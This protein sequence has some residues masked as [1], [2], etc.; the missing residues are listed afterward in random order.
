MKSEE[1]NLFTEAAF[2]T[3]PKMV[4]YNKENEILNMSNF[5]NE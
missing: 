4:L 5:Q 3:A 2:L 1:V